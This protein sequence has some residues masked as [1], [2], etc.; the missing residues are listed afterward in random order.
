MAGGGSGRSTG[1]Q[2]QGPEP[3]PLRIDLFIAFQIISTAWLVPLD[4]VATRL[5]VQPYSPRGDHYASLGQKAS[6]Q[7]ELNEEGGAPHGL[8][9]CGDG[10][11]VIALRPV[12]E[13]YEGMIDCARKLASEEGVGSLYRGWIWSLL[14]NVL[15][16]GG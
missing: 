4:V 5:S 7:F 13:P 2:W 11:D 9:Y 16:S 10:E 8:E 12:T 14:G 1:A 3:T 6:D 15:Q